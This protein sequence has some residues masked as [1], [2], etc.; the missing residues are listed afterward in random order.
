MAHL[1]EEG[2]SG[3]FPY[4]GWPLP[5]RMCQ[6]QNKTLQSFLRNSFAGLWV[7]SEFSV[8]GADVQ[9]DNMWG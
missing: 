6:E 9:R 4:K 8:P 7:P 2:F 3:F 1:G 5:Y